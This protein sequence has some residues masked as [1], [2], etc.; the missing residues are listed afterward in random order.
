[1]VAPAPEDEVVFLTEQGQRVLHGR[2]IGEND[3][4]LKL[5]RR[6]GDWEIKKS[7]I[8]TIRRGRR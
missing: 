8:V 3:L 1:M 7:Q 5:S 2:I 4:F 6:D